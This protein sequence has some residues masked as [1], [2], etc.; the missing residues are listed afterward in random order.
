MPGEEVGARVEMRTSMVWLR[1][2]C[3]EG[4]PEG[5]AGVATCGGVCRVKG[6]EGQGR[7]GRRHGCD[8]AWEVSASLLGDGKLKLVCA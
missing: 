7:A 4:F 3:P 1:E 5:V 8:R 6:G 2:R